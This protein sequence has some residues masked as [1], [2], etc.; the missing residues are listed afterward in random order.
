MGLIEDS[1]HLLVPTQSAYL[2][3][4]LL[5]RLLVACEPISGNF[6]MKKVGDSCCESI[7]S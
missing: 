4:S 5:N 2:K 3:W 6:S 7:Q 1:A